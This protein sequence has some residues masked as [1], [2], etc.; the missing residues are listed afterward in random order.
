[1]G[2]RDIKLNNCYADPSMIREVLAYEIARMYM[3]APQANFAILYINGNYQG[4]YTNAEAINSA[5]VARHFYS[6]SGTLVK[7]NPNLTPSPGVKSNLK[8]I[9]NSD[10]SG[11]YNYYEM[12][13]D[14]GWNYLKNLC[15]SVTNN[16]ASLSR[17][18]DMDRACWMLAFNNLLVNLDSY[19]GT[20]AQNYYL[21]RDNAGWFNPITW[22]LNMSFGG[23]PFLGSSNTSL[24]NLSIAGMQN[25]SPAIHSTD[26][27]WPLIKAVYDNPTYKRKYIA[28]LKTM[29]DEVFV[30]GLYLTRYNYY[31]NLISN[32]VL[33]DSNKFYSNTQFQNALSANVSVGSYSVPGIQTLMSARVTYLQSVPDFTYAAPAISGVSVA[34]APL[35]SGAAITITANISAASAGSVY[36]N[37]RHLASAHFS[38]TLMYD[39]GQHSDGQASDNI[40]GA[41]FTLSA[42]IAQYYVYAENSAAGVFSPARAEHEFNE[43][44]IYDAPAAADVTINEFLADNKSDVKNEFHLSEDWIE[45]Y[46]NTSKTLD[47]TGLYLTDD[48]YD[49]SKYQFPHNTL[50]QSHAFL[51]IWAD[52]IYK[53]TQ[54]QI[55]A[56]FKLNNGNGSITLSNGAY[57]V[58][59]N[60]L[61]GVQET[62]VSYGRCEDGTGSFRTFK[63]P[64]YGMQNCIVGLNEERLSGSLIVYPNPAASYV[65]VQTR[66]ETSRRLIVR[67]LLGELVFEESVNGKSLIDISLWN[68]GIYV[69]NVGEH[70]TKLIVSKQK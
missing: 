36:L 15:D 69:V 27:Y 70:S 4:L 68:E 8:Y 54:Q 50:I 33:S 31:Y 41:M 40:Y 48:Q 67:N 6:N 11:Y 66:D 26:V 35:T 52:N 64:T 14:Y 51:I 3:D 30:S 39:D 47:L 1:M 56:N 63:Y 61:Y 21:Y 57:G 45:L 10:S 42:N 60:V 18:I 16:P 2:L 65:N 25:M 12:K 28:H 49:A 19:S 43:F 13:S 9:P 55:H 37:Y 23:F 58:V 38:Q 59:D 17:V 34:N 5:F 53:I 46:N 44:R 32:A 20:F 29:L 7:C 24:A 62:D 22:D